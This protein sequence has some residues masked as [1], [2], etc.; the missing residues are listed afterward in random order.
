ML[1]V[2][3]AFS[4]P[5]AVWAQKKHGVRPYRTDIERERM[6]WG[7]KLEPIILAEYEER[8]GVALE[9][10]PQDEHWLHP[11]HP[12]VPMSCTPDA[13]AMDED[14]VIYGVDSKTSGRYSHELSLPYEVQGQHQMACCGWGKVVFPLL[15]AG[16]RFATY[17]VYRDDAFI[18][19]LEL[20]LTR[21]WERYMVGDEIPPIDSHSAT[22]GA[23][24]AMFPDHTNLAVVL[25]T[26]CTEIDAELREI[27]DKKKEL[28]K[29]EAHLK[30]ILKTQIGDAHE[31]V[32]QGTTG[33][34]RWQTISKKATTTKATQYRQLRRVK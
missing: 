13:Q 11:R 17:E 28:S 4:S 9:R 10:W 32:L 7:H 21:W 30:N 2:P 15:A 34:W 25:S 6:E 12:A 26:E 27:A 33:A 24:D 23:I 19:Q 18:A 29:R 14:G 22:K 16:Q 5:W 3:G 31:G 1:G 20:T 8:A